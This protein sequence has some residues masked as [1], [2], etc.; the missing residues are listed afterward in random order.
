M[1]AIF[2]YN[3]LLIDLKVIYKIKI[4]KK[5]WPSSSPSFADEKPWIQREIEIEIEWLVQGHT[6]S[7]L[8]K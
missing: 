8:Y 6:A 3:W 2:M 4:R 7:Q 1:V 5:F